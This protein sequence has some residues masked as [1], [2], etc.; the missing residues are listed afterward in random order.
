MTYLYDGD[1]TF[2]KSFAKVAFDEQGN[3][4][5]FT[6]KPERGKKFVTLLLGEV[7]GKAQ[8]ADLDA[9]LLKLGYAKVQP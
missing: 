8:D 9:M 5:T 6:F 3:Q 7:D 2:T 1:A 4:H